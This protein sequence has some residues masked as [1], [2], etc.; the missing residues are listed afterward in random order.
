[1][2]FI[3]FEV[4]G[5]DFSNHGLVGD[6][7]LEAGACDP[8]LD[9]GR[10]SAFNAGDSFRAQTLGPLFKGALSFLL[11]SFEVIESGSVTIAE[12]LSAIAAANDTD[13]LTAADRIAA[14]I[15]QTPSRRA[16]VRALPGKMYCLD[17]QY[18]IK[19]DKGNGG[20]K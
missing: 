2:K 4:I 14:V 9:G 18:R 3:E 16:T 5:R 10:M 17:P 8:K 20:V 15:S 7:S 19:K 6:L 12:S 13:G 1:M 11:R